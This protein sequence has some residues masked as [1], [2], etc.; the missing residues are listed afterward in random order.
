M[1]RYNVTFQNGSFLE[2][3]TGKRI[4]PQQGKSYV[5]AGDDDA[6]ATK[7]QNLSV[8]QVLEPE[9]KLRY[10]RKKY[11]N[12]EFEQILDVDE[13]VY[14][15]LSLST[16]LKYNIKEEFIFRVH[17][18]EP[19]YLYKNRESDGIA[20][21]NWRLADCAA[22]LEECVEGDLVLFE[23]I[24]MPSLNSLYAAV[25]QFYFK[26]RRSPSANAFKTFYRMKN[27]NQGYGRVLGSK[28]EYLEELRQQVVRRYKP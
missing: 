25:I 9:E 11:P 19:L 5:L 13:I 6:F 12:H 28:L 20:K 15:K 14:F 1:K 22:R 21:S 7:D 8:T 16:D 24:E 26:F 27:P 3:G 23:K 4:I 2:T 18:L 10:F 17:I